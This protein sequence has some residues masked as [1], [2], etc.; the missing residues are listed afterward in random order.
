MN[1]QPHIRIGT[2]GWNYGHWRGRF[3]PEDLPANRWFEHYA[4]AF[5]TVEINNTFYQLPAAKTFQNWDQQA[6]PGFVYAVKAN[7][8]ITHLKKLKDPMVPLRRFFNR[9]RRLGRHLGPILFQLPP[10]WKPGLERLDQFCAALPRDLTHVIEFRERAWLQEE[11][12]GV[13]MAHGVCLC[14][15]DLIKRH[16]R[17]VT[18]RAVYIRFHGAGSKYGESYS[19]RRLGRWADWMAEAAQEKLQVYAYFNNDRNACAVRNARTLRNILASRSLTA[20]RGRRP[21]PKA[22]L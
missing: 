13:L 16:P 7:R 21:I 9:A 17:R 11:T 8:Y 22:W 19:R 6:P 4:G 18:G 20:F 15:H 1:Q 5:D 12:Y 14:V 10:H 2:S 3:Y